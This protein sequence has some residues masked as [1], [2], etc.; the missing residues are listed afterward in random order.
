MNVLVNGEPRELPEGTT[1]ARL[2][3][4][5]DGVPG[6]RGV[7]VALD[8]E[9]VSRGAWSATEVGEGVTVEIVVAVQGG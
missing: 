9:V 7:A 5:L 6:G 4:S 8:G 1:V 2:V 3:E